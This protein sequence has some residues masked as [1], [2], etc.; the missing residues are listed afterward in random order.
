MGL[1]LD[2]ILHGDQPTT[3]F[4]GVVNGHACQ[5]LPLAYEVKQ[6]CLIAAQPESTIPDWAKLCHNSRVYLHGFQRM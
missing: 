3:R 2:R 5:D 1:L 6:C 4:G